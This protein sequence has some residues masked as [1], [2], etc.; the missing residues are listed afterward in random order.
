MLTNELVAETSVIVVEEGQV[1]PLPLCVPQE[2]P[3]LSKMLCF[4]KC[5]RLTDLRQFLHARETLSIVKKF[6]D[7][8]RS[9]RGNITLIIKVLCATT[10]EMH[11]TNV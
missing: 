1:Q 10:A 5:V 8:F 3:S 7:K 9:S 6:S 11:D 4:S 2:A